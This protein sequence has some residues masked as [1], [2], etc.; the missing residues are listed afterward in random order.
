MPIFEYRCTSCQNEFE[1]LVRSGDI[2]ACP[3]CA[4]QN[5]A[6]L[7]SLPAIKSDSTHALAL[8]AAHRR[9]KIQQGDKAREQR[10]YELHHDD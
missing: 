6:K 9:D 4:S 3:K 8:K 1:T 2:P 5:L 10:E 7:L